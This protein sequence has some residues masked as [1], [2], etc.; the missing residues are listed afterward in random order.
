[1]LEA[2][3]DNLGILQTLGP[4]LRACCNVIR[5]PSHTS[6]PP[7]LLINLLV[8]KEEVGC[9]SGEW[10]CK[11]AQRNVRGMADVRI[12]GDGVDVSERQIQSMERDIHHPRPRTMVN[13]GEHGR[14]HF[15]RV[16]GAS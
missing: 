4:S 1:M 6:S 2:V 7:R 14:V 13:Q 16:L 11:A 12:M 9:I 15:I 8:E 10:A 5:D 3:R